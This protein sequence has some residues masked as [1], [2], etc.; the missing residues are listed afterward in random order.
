MKHN[1]TRKKKFL[2]GYLIK[3]V[4]FHTKGITKKNA[5]CGSGSKFWFVRRQCES[6]TKATKHS[7]G[8]IIHWWMIKELIRRLMV[9]KRTKVLFIKNVAMKRLSPQ[10]W[11]GTRDWNS[12]SL[13][14][15][16]RW[17]CLC[18]TTEFCLGLSAQENWCI[19]PF[20]LKKIMEYQFRC[21]IWP[22]FLHPCVKL[23]LNHR[24]KLENN[25]PSF[26]FV[27][28]QEYSSETC[29]IINQSKKIL[30]TSMSRNMIRT[31]SVTMDKIKST[32]EKDD[33]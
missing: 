22:K 24:E 7:K 13:A 5:C 26:W 2:C 10:N 19:I 29:T 31:Q 18:S 3:L 33:Y 32:Y 6:K 25:I 21:I 4:A 11:I 27:P 14:T 12:N 30:V 23:C 9:Q 17:W 15:L 20:E 16:R 8:I 1:I 28:H